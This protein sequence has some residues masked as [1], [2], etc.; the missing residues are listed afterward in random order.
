MRPRKKLKRR[1]PPPPQPELSDDSDPENVA[2]YIKLL[3]TEKEI[4]ESEK[5]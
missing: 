3:R 2:Y 5:N 4:Q 1:R